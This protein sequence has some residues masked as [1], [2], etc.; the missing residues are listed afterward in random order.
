MAELRV[1]EITT[2]ELWEEIL[3]TARE[4]SF[5]QAWQN[6]ELQK[7]MGHI[8]GR[9]IVCNGDTSLLMGQYFII[10]AKRGK[11][12]Q[13]RHAPIILPGFESQSKSEQLLALNQFLAEVRE[14]AK[15]ANC[16]FVRMQPLV[17]LDSE[18]LLPEL[19]HKAGYRPANIHNIDAEKTLILDISK[20]E[21]VLQENMRKQTRYYTRKAEKMGV[22]V[23]HEQSITAL[24][25]FYKIHHDTTIRQHFTSYSHEYYQK[26]FAAFNAIEGSRLRAEVFTAQYDGKDIAAAIIVFLSSKA[27]YSDGGS[28]TAYNKI[29]ASYL[30]QWKAIQRAKELG[31]QTYNFWGG[32]S[33]DQENKNYP[34]YGIDLFKRGFGGDRVDYMH[35][36]DLSLSWFYQLTRIWELIEKYRRGY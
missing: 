8:V 13:L 2:W 10:N 33:P 11:V 36:H 3:L 25:N 18:S 20:E 29:P 16:H 34:W 4:F 17:R 23:R 15:T 32:V 24:E 30:I 9:F 21:S 27:F 35:V 1:K 28:L 19:M 31:C 5:L 26:S 14:R 6:G 7:Q 22:V 12:M